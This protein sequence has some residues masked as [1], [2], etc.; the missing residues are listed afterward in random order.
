MLFVRVG[1]AFTFLYA[2][3]ASL[4]D[5]GIWSGFVP[6]FVSSILPAETFLKLFAAFQILLGVVLLSGRMLRLAGFAAVVSL[7]GIVIFNVSAW[8]IVFRDVGL[9]FAALALV[10]YGRR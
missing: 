2:G 9:A 7:V 4:L 10:F 3:V 5:P 1:L 8:D 6:G